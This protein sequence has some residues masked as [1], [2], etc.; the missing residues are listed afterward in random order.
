[1]SVCL[2]V[3]LSVNVCKYEFLLLKNKIKWNPK[4]KKDQ[5]RTKMLKKHLQMRLTNASKCPFM[6]LN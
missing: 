2:S 5:E 6:A 3:C 4:E 1:M